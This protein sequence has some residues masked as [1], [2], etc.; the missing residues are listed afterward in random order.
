[1][2][3]TNTILVF[4]L[5]QTKK[6][7]PLFNASGQSRREVSAELSWTMWLELASVFA[8][9]SFAF[10]RTCHTQD[11]NRCGRVAS[12]PGCRSHGQRNGWI[13]GSIF[14]HLWNATQK[15]ITRHDFD[16]SCRLGQRKP[17]EMKHPPTRGGHPNVD[18][19]I[20]RCCCG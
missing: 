14:C 19:G 3:A 9:V 7:V 10:C 8:S 5:T 12:D 18:K 20:L 11:R 6:Y 2:H 15:L 17:T 4:L 1:M 13:V 16:L